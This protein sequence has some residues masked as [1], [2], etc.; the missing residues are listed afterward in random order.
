MQT[1]LRS[2]LL[3]VFFGLLFHAFGTNGFAQ[4]QFKPGDMLTPDPAIKIGKLDNGLIYYVRENKKPEKRCELRLAVKVGSVVEDDDQLGLAHFVE[5]MAFN[6]TEKFPKLEII[7]YLE[8]TGM[9]FGPEVNAGTSFDQTVYMLQLPTDSLPVVKKGFQILQEWAQHVAF[10]GSE[11]EKERGVIIEEWRL[12]RGAQMRILMQQLPFLLYNSQYAQRFVI[13]KKEILESFQHET[14]RRYYRDWYRP[15]LMAVV[16]VGDFNAKE[17]ESWI[18]EHFSGLKNPVPERPRKEYPVPTHKET[19]VSIATDAELTMSMAQIIFKRPATDTYTAGDYRDEIVDRLCGAMLSARYAER[20][21]KPNPPYIFAA[22][23]DQRFLGNVQITALVAALKENS[24]L[25]GID[26]LVTEAY[27][28][29]QH[30]F[31]AT[32]L[33]RQKKQVL[34]QYENMF[35]EREKRQSRALADEYVRNFLQRETIPGIE[36]EY[37]VVRQFLPGIELGEVN[38]R[39][40]ERIRDEGRVITVALPKKESLKVPGEAEILATFHAASARQYEPYVDKVSTQ[41]LLAKLPPPGRVVSEKKMESLGATEWTLS[42]GAR[43][44]LKPTDF[45]NDEILFS[46]Y[47]KGGHSL[48]SDKDYRSAQNATSLV[49][50]SGVGEFDAIVLQKMLAGKLVNVSP[51]I[52]EL[53]EGFSGNAAP[54][55]LETLFQMVY[56]YSTAPRKDTAAISALMTRMRAA[57][58]NRSADPNSVFSD[59]VQVTMTNYNHRVR[60]FT[61]A[62]LSEIDPDKALAIYKDRFSDFSDFTFFFVGNFELEKIKPLVEQYLASLPSLNRK[63]SWRD[64]GVKTPPGTVSKSVYKGAEAKSSVQLYL[65]GPFDW[66]AQNRYEFNS[67]MELMRIKLRE[68]IREEKGGTYGIGISGSASL[69]PRKE[70]TVSINWGCAPDRV[71]ELIGAVMQ[72]LDSL[73]MKRPDQVYVDKVKEQQRRTYEV[74]LKENNFWISNFRT[75]IANGENPEGILQYPSYVEKLSGEAIQNVA[76]TYLQLSSLKRFVLYPEKKD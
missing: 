22:G 39:I 69:Y 23:M 27:R 51:S 9:K 15:N 68:V 43:V 65:N 6:G 13:G 36:V 26:A 30:G 55:D 33:E 24:V 63:E 18:K 46:S 71:D 2:F 44:I 48:V 45:K 20:T 38:K 10:E 72:Q 25:D 70:Y 14:L 66:S 50:Q 60:P 49:S 3:T 11:I 1:S 35:K 32:E 73:K 8:K 40:A 41:P 67:L 19:F 59:T 57:L 61:A 16:A 34:S 56:L 58:Q 62:L 29:K 47:S 21:Q 28:G 31:T 42:N 53:S 12:G 75:H 7:N 52:S 4:Q 37:E 5:H 74:N 76:K 64:I 54:K 17:M